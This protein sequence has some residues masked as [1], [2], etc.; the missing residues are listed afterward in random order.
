MLNGW[1]SYRA[2]LQARLRSGMRQEQLTSSNDNL[3]DDGRPLL[4]RVG[5]NDAA[6]F[7]M[8]VRRYRR[9][10]WFLARQSLRN[11]A[12]A[13]DAVQ[14]IFLAI[15]RNAHRFD[16]GRASEKTFIAMIARRWL[17]D[18]YRRRLHR[19]DAH[20]LTPAVEAESCACE[21]DGNDGDDEGAQWL[22]GRISDLQRQVLELSLVHG[23][24]Y[25]QVARSMGLPLSTV[26]SLAQSA[27]KQIR[28][29]AARLEG[30]AT[31][32]AARRL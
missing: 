2:A 19:R 21:P 3:N 32:A 4:Q 12:D 14:D 9:L 6:A 10:I 1:L 24:T 7:D 15:W 8:C 5:R 22:L 18:C 28:A 27:L 11:E 25:P 13:E 20:W 29:D 26:K 16:P 17:I 30:F 23:T 31:A